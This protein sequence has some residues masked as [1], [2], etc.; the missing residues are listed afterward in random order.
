[1]RKIKAEDTSSFDAAQNPQSACKQPKHVAGYG[2]MFCSPA[3]EKQEK[4]SPIFL[5]WVPN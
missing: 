3:L 5:D 1:M 2:T 4:P